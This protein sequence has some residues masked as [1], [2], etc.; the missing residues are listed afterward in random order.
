MFSVQNRGSLM[1][2]ALRRSAMESAVGTPLRTVAS[3]GITAAE[4]KHHQ[5]KQFLL[6]YVC[7]CRKQGGRHTFRQGLKRKYT[8]SKI[9]EFLKTT[10]KFC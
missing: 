1:A 7:L 2:T 9:A 5:D 3:P 4:K 10:T 6:T 8:N